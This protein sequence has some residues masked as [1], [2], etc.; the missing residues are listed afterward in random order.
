ME[1]LSASQQLLSANKNEMILVTE[2]AGRGGWV[3]WTQ[4]C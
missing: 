3:G 4:V 2:D 1:R